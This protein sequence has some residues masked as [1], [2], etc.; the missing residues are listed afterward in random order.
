MLYTITVGRI[1][2]KVVNTNFSLK[3]HNLKYHGFQS[4]EALKLGFA[5]TE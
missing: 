5:D 3:Y 4:E 2:V 1:Y